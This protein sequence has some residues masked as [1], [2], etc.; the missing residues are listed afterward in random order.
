WGA[1]ARGRERPGDRHLVTSTPRQ[2][3]LPPPPQRLARASDASAISEL[4]RASVLDLFPH[5][6]I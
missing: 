5:F 2:G 3:A 6:S 1:A 4:M